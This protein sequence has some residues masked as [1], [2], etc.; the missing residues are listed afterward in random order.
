MGIQAADRGGSRPFGRFRRHLEAAS[1][2]N[3]VTGEYPQDNSLG[4][5]RG[6]FL[7][8]NL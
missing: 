7:D 1:Q 4:T 3:P 8:R 5:R 2:A 6:L